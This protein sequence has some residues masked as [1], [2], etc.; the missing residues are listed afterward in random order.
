M[1]EIFLGLTFLADRTVFAF[2]GA[3]S[4]AVVHCFDCSLVSDVFQWIHVSLTVTKRGRNS[5]G[6][7]LNSL[8]H[9]SEMV[10]RLR[11]L[12]GVSKRGT[13]CVYRFLMQDMTHAVFSDAY[14]F[15]YLAHLQ[16]AV[17]EYKLMDFFT[18]SSVVAIFRAP[19]RGS[20]K[21]DM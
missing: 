18:L 15:S 11:L 19:E 14:C 12:S 2:F 17:C 9:C 6:L 7:H 16:S 10:S 5:F 3:C 13:H 21:P 4:L 8:K 20:L 1:E